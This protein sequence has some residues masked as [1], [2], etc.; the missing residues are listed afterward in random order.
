MK[1]VVLDAATLGNDITFEKWEKL[2]ELT[3]YQTTPENMV[4]ERLKNCDAVILNKVKITKEVLNSLPNLKL[5]CVTATGY[6]N[7]DIDTCRKNNVA[8]CNVTGYSTD[9]VAQVTVSMALALYTNLFTFAKHVS[10]GAYTKEKIQNCLT[11]V[12]HLLKGKTWGVV[13][14]GNIGK[15][16]AEIATAFGCKVICFKKTPTNDFNCVD[17]NTLC[18]ESDII[19]LHVPLN[20][21]TREIINQNTLSLMKPTAILIN[22]ARGAVTDESAVV[23]A[24]KENKLGGFATDVYSVEPLEYSSPLNEIANLPNVILTP[25]MA[26]GAFESRLILVDEIAKNIEA[27]KKGELRQRVDISKHE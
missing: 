9:S 25:H 14:M 19:S 22:S 13:G 5:I 4:I 8:I 6:D 16:V 21:N 15:K 2:G 7:I 23:K 12:F 17:L 26:W 20:E 18:K 11:P 27:F 1:I 24:V 3:V 10:S